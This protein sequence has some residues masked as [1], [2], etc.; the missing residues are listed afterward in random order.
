MI[1]EKF[2]L[3]VVVCTYNR[4]DAAIRAV[5]SVI[6]ADLDDVGVIIHSN[7]PDSELSRF[8]NAND[9]A[10]YYGEHVSNLGG[11]ANFESAVK[12]FDARYI[13][14]LSDEDEL[15]LEGF[16]SIIERLRSLKDIDIFALSP[17]KDYFQLSSTEDFIADRKE[18]LTAYSWILT[19]MSGFIFPSKIVD[20][21][22]FSRYFRD[23]SYSHL[24]YKMMMGVD[25]LFVIPKQ[26]YVIKN[27]DVM[28]GGDAY[29]H[30]EK[31]GL[32]P[33]HKL[34]NPTVYGFEGRVAQYYNL[35]YLQSRFGL[36]GYIQ[37]VI[38]LELAIQ[39]AASYQQSSK[40]TQDGPRE[41]K[42]AEKSHKRYLE[43]WPSSQIWS[44]VFRFLC[45]NFSRATRLTTALSYSLKIYRRLFRKIIWG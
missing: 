13:M 12:L 8:M 4:T 14:L 42:M 21:S 39:W 36:T 9:L 32:A 10:Q 6:N 2:L 40:V 44:Y 35:A 15:D 41:R 34:K 23:C 31:G 3:Q 25:D 33:G 30:V 27:D 24:I 5:K 37:A 1:Q 26:P 11:V 16:K 17:V 18:A 20:N 19:Y 7:S 38:S 29:E 45:S 43:L 22:H 28:Y